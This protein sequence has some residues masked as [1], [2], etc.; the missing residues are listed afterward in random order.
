MH[1]G[2]CATGQSRDHPAPANG[3][4]FGNRLEGFTEREPDV[5]RNKEC[6]E[7]VREGLAVVGVPE[8]GQQHETGQGRQPV[9][10]GYGAEQGDGQPNPHDEH[11]ETRF[12]FIV[13]RRVEPGQSKEHLCANDQSDER[14]ERSCMVVQ[15][16]C[17]HALGGT[18]QHRVEQ[19]VRKPSVA[20]E[21]QH[22]GHHGKQEV[23]LELDNTHRHQQQNRQQEQATRC[24]EH[25]QQEEHDIG[26]AIAHSV[27]LVRVNS[28]P[29]DDSVDDDGGADEN[30]VQ[31]H[32]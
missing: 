32:V 7:H 16:V 28:T 17:S 15:E 2:H 8:V 10:V 4:R 14:R 27:Q 9:T 22:Q 6:P 11:G 13:F 19:T 23:E 31:Q 21:H 20:Q 18:L 24:I 26:D 1:D 3:I 29:S 12:Q 30:Q 5:K 25:G